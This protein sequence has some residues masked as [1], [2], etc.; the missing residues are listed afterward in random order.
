MAYQ[1]IVWPDGRVFGVV[2]GQEREQLA[3]EGEALLLVLRRESRDG[4]RWRPRSP[5]CALLE[6]HFRV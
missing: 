2:L 6:W 5:R 1:P 4:A 3:D